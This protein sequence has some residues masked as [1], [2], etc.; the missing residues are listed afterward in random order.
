MLIAFTKDFAGRKVGTVENLPDRA[1]ALFVRKGYATA[2]DAKPTKRKPARK[3]VKKP[4]K[5]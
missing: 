5:K 2:K 3:P 1:A 4:V